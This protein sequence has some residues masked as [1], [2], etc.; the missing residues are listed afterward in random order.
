[1]LKQLFLSV[2]AGSILLTSV[3]VADQADEAAIRAENTAWFKGYNTANAKMVSDLYAD[4]AVLLAPGSAMIHGKKAIVAYYA[5]D[6]ADTKAQ[7]MTYVQNPKSD[8]SISDTIAWESGEFKAMVKGAVVDSG[9]YLTVSR[10][11]DGQWK[12]IRDT[13]NSDAPT[14]APQASK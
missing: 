11:K 14:P 10:K 4:E 12:I 2:I 13:W 8:I 1:M 9:K 3:S 5:K 6:V 7:G